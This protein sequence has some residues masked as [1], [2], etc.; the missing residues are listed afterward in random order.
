MNMHRLKVMAVTC[1]AG[2]SAT[3]CTAGITSVGPATS[4]SPATSH[5]ASSPTGSPSHTGPASA[6]SGD[7]VSLNAPTG[8]FPIPHGAHAG[9]N[10][11]CGKQVIIQLESV[12]PTQ[13]SAFY[14]SALPHAGYKI[15]D[16]TLSS[17]PN[18]GAPYGMAE[19]SFTGHG[20]TGQISAFANLGT[21]S[22]AGTSPSGLPISLPSSLT[23]NVVQI[24]MAPT[25]EAITSA[26][27]S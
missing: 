18:T 23:K 15:T 11:S 26:C 7:T 12:A 17:D 27:L 10:M 9:I 20:Y 3:A 8:S 24:F 4:A 21:E 2:L 6:G 25:G 14:T 5:A 16:D 19:I 13:A 22:P 1:A